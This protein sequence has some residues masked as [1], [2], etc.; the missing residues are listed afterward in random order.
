MGKWA[1]YLIIAI[2]VLAIVG[3]LV[4]AARA[5]AWILLVVCAAVLVGRWLMGRRK[6]G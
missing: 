4:D 3:F 2:V 1:T 5:I 6:S